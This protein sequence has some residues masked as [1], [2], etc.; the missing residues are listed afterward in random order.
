MYLGKRTNDFARDQTRK[1]TD[2]VHLMSEIL[3]AIKLIKFYAWESPFAE[4]IN[5]IRAEEMQLIYDSMINKTVNYTVVFAVPVL[6]ALTCLSMVLPS[7]TVRCPR[8]PIDCYSLIHC[9][10]SV[11]H[12]AVPVLYASHGR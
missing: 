3:T 2:R 1:T 9:P 6:T 10:V 5:E 7:N 4:K 8:K 11:Q 12:I